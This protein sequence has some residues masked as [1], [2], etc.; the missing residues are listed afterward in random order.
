MFSKRAC[1]LSQAMRVFGAGV[2][3]SGGEN[4]QNMKGRAPPS[5]HIVVDMLGPGEHIN[6]LNYQQ[7]KIVVDALPRSRHIN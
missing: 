4:K 5:R 3:G 2:T 1:P 6:C 7:F